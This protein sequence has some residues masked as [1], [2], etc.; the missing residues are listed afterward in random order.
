MK[1][2]A[3]KFSWLSYVIHV[4]K[5]YKNINIIPS[6]STMSYSKNPNVL[7][8]CNSCSSRSFLLLMNLITKSHK[9]S[10]NPGHVKKYYNTVAQYT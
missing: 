2:W 7:S 9:I 5:N 1:K 3:L 4:T 6:N 10:K 8:S